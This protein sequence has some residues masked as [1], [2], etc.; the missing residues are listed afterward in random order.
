MPDGAGFFLHHFLDI[1][2]I[3]GQVKFKEGVEIVCFDAVESG[4]LYQ[5]RDPTPF[6]EQ[7]P[8]VEQ[9]CCFNVCYC[10]AGIAPVG[11]LG[12]YR[13]DDYLKGRFSRPPVLGAKSIV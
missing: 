12:E 7:F 2:V 10:P 11:V 5:A 9:T 1:A 6:L 4:S 13:A 8:R 3:V